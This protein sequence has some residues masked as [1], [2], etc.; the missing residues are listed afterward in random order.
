MSE[1]AY[2]QVRDKINGTFV[3]MGEQYLKNI[4]YP[5]R[6]YSLGA[7]SGKVPATRPGFVVAK[8]RPS[9]GVALTLDQRPI[10]RRGLLFLVLGVAVIF[11]I[12]GMWAWQGQAPLT[13]P[14]PTPPPSAALDTL[15]KYQRL[16]LSPQP[17]QG[18]VEDK[19][20]HAPRLSIVVLPFVNWTGDP[21]QE[22]L[23]DGLTADL[24]RNLSGL[25]DSFVVDQVTASEYKGRT[26]KERLLG[27]ELGVRYA[28]EGSV[29]RVGH[30]VMVK[31]QLIS[32]ETGVQVWEDSFEG[33]PDR[34]G[35]LQVEFVSRISNAVWHELTTR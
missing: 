23:S 8:S 7:R 32:T 27:S 31:A 20:V 30:S 29:H 21:K 28:L 25:P 12:L 15:D 10:G 34:L 4:A 3:D 18:A 19:L 1:D 16:S 5:I 14:S 9:S 13:P 35:E 6:T 2:R 33:E 11:A 26:V 17:R 22:D 24:T